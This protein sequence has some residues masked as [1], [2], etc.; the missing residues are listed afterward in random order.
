[1][2]IDAHTIRQAISLGISEGMKNGAAHVA[3]ALAEMAPRSTP[4]IDDDVQWVVNDNAELGVKIGEQ[5]FWLYKGE[6]L[7]YDN[8]EH[9]DGRP[10]MWRTVGKREFGECCHPVNY[11]DPRMI[12][13][14]SLDDSDRWQQLPPAAPGVSGVSRHDAEMARK[15]K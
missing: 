7:V 8:A 3:E 15:D 10:M 4:L 12:G 1:M 14:V 11:K 6:S 13:T 5:F 2:M 9:D